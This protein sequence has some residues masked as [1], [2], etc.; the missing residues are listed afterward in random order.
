MIE[1]KR[2]GW[3]AGLGLI[4]ATLGRADAGLVQIG[5]QHFA[6]GQVITDAM[7]ASAVNG[8]P[9][10]F[11]G[12]IGSDTNA[13]FSATYSFAI[14]AQAVSS[15]T[16]SIGIF[17]ADSAAAG[18]QVGAFSI[19][20]I[21]LTALLNS[22]FNGHGGT[23]QEYDVYTITLPSA[24]LASIAAGQANVSLT[25]A[26]PGLGGDPGS[27]NMTTPYNGAGLDFSNIS[28]NPSAVPEPSSL[29]LLGV[30]GLIGCGVAR[31]R[32]A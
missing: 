28:I 23:Q 18:D 26:G 29:A 20:G 30:G 4:L 24:A 13:D 22:A 5:T 31:R 12:F 17:D 3:V 10:P 11:N 16:F 2:W 15:A 32:R 6:D 14:G 19:N 1:P 25:L 8:Q 21:D 9:A 7:Y 27:S